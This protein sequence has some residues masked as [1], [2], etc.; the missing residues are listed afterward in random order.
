MR[1]PA[2]TRRAAGG[3]SG[4]GKRIVSM[5]LRW[6]FDVLTMYLRCT[7]DVSSKDLALFDLRAPSNACSRQ[8][9]GAYPLGSHFEE[10]VAL[11][12]AVGGP[13]C[14]RRRSGGSRGPESGRSV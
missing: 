6:F 12:P 4:C 1:P 14:L 3:Q 8:S 2:L 9:P 5:V 7:Y 13:H 10:F 11:R